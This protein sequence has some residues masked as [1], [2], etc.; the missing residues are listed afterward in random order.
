MAIND[1][2]GKVKCPKCNKNQ[3]SIYYF[4]SDCRGND[5]SYGGDCENCGFKPDDVRLMKL[6]STLKK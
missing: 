5:S 1:K 3:L 6:L 4:D 2:W